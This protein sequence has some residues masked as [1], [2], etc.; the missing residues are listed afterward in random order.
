MISQNQEQQQITNRKRRVSW[1]VDESPR[2]DARDIAEIDE[3]ITSV[4]R[5]I[6]IDNCY[7]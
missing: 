5:I 3:E 6:L 7:N 4:R 2:R 1:M